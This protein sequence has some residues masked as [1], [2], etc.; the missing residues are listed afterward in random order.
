MGNNNR[1]FTD[2]LL[3]GIAQFVL[4]FLIISVIWYLVSEVVDAFR[5]GKWDKILKWVLVIF[6][7]W[8][9]IKWSENE[10]LKR[11]SIQKKTEDTRSGQEIWNENMKDYDAERGY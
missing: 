6:V 5:Y 8:L 1:S 2:R 4:I 10:Q 7:L 9:I 11:E 3:E